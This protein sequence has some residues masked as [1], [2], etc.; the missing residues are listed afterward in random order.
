MVAHTRTLTLS[1][2]V[3]AR[4]IISMVRSNSELQVGFLAE[5]RRMNVAVTRA[6]RYGPGVKSQHVF[7]VACCCVT[8]IS[9]GYEVTVQ[10]CDGDMRLGHGLDRPV[11]QANGGVLSAARRIPRS[12]R[13][14]VG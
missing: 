10:S 5:K 13:V 14:L 12:E 4:Q 6:R 9:C 11:P 2:C 8:L 7:C 1:L 3:R